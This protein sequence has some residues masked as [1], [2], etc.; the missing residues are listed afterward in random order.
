MIYDSQFGD[1]WQ[2]SLFQILKCQQISEH[3]VVISFITKERFCFPHINLDYTYLNWL[4]ITDYAHTHNTNKTYVNGGNFLLIDAHFKIY[5]HLNSVNKFSSRNTNAKCPIFMNLMD[6]LLY[7]Y[8][9]FEKKT[10]KV[11]GKPIIFI[12][13]SSNITFCNIS[14]Y[15]HFLI[16]V[17]I[18]FRPLMKLFM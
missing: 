15:L 1:F 13:P 17:S 4:L 2:L 8:T 6:T 16:I 3:C 5:T 9:Q 10:Q 14:L 11:S 12:M 18:A 7:S